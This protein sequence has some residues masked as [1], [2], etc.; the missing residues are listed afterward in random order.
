MS[1]KLANIGVLVGALLAFAAVV[2]M[3]SG[4]E[5]AEKGKIAVDVIILFGGLFFAFESAAYQYR[6]MPTNTLPRNG[7]FVFETTPVIENQVARETPGVTIV[8]FLDKNLVS[9]IILLSPK[10]KKG[11]QGSTKAYRIKYENIL[12]S[13]SDDGLTQ[14]E[15]FNAIKTA[16]ADDEIRFLSGG[17]MIFTKR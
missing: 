4:V 11:R 10:G 14:G 15:L 3:I 2:L 5:S 9:L 6:G 12:P 17:K 7:T 13:G 8:D 16:Q 1:K